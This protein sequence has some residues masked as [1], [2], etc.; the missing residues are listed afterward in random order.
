MIYLENISKKYNDRT[1]FSDVRFTVPDGTFCSIS[2]VSGSGK[3]TLLKIMSGMEQ[4]STG[5]VRFN[6]T[7]I[8]RKR[9]SALWRKHFSFV[10]QN[11]FLLENKSVLFN[12]KLANRQIQVDMINEVLKMVGLHP[13][14]LKQEVYTLS[15]GEKQRVGIARATLKPFDVLFADE[16]TGNLDQQNAIGVRD[17]FSELCASG[18]TV[19]VVSHDEMFSSVADLTFHLDNSKIIAQTR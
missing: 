2:G 10:F 7:D 12:L 5:L 4:P 19:V 3:T 8:N 6:D 15:G 11:Y 17:I 16:P 13:D 9:T 1:L 18:K 14:I